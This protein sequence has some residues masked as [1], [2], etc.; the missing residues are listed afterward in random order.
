MKDA[1]LE[2]MVHGFDRRAG[3]KFYYSY[4]PTKAGFTAA[5]SFF[6][7][8]PPGFREAIVARHVAY[9]EEQVAARQKFVTFIKAKFEAKEDK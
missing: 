1:E 6:L 2:N 3:R 4:Q 9:S 8:L 7:L 5:E